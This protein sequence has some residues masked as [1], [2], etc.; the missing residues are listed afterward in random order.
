MINTYTVNS[1]NSD[2]HY[3]VHVFASQCTHGKECIPHC[4][5]GECSYLC[6]HMISCTCYDFS[7]GHLCKHAHKVQA[8][9]LDHTR[10]QAASFTRY[11]DNFWYV[12]QYCSCIYM[13]YTMIVY[14]IAT[15]IESP[16][17]QIFKVDPGGT[18]TNETGKV[19]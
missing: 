7:H 5:E 9:Q 14:P 6:R 4:V 10:G 18:S 15:E 3:T 8:V 16:A 13:Y 1:E 11:D 2:Q 12:A 19:C 17:K